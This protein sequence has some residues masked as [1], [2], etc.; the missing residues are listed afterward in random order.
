M[1]EFLREIARICLV[2]VWRRVTHGL[3]SVLRLQQSTKMFSAVAQVEATALAEGGRRLGSGRAA[4]LLAVKTTCGT[5][6]LFFI[7]AV[8]GG[9]WAGQRTHRR[10]ETAGAWAGRLDLCGT[11]HLSTLHLVRLCDGRGL[12]GTASIRNYLPILG[13]C[14]M[15]GDVRS[16]KDRECKLRPRRRHEDT[17]TFSTE[18]RINS[19]S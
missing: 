5:T 3:R 1:P 9:S 4:L 18:A 15:E 10:R 13:G 8:G 2:Y 6:P 19:A 16:V 12:W 11:A 14:A 7:C 17:Q